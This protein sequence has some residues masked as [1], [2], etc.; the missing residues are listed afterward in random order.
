[1]KYELAAEV[2]QLHLDG[3]AD[4]SQP[5]L[6]R[7][8]QREE[9][10]LVVQKRCGPGEDVIGQA[11]CVAHF[12]V[13][14]RERQPFFDLARVLGIPSVLQD[15]SAAFLWHCSGGFAEAVLL[16]RRYAVMKEAARARRR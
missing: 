12:A 11:R 1:M 8:T 9:L 5:A 13:V 6:G 15:A 7:G 16:R 10:L 14:A 4:D 2:C 3:A